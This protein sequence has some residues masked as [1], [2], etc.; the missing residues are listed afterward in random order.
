MAYYDGNESIAFCAGFSDVASQ[1]PCNATTDQFAFGSTTKV[2]TSVIIL[3]LQERGLLAL[4]DLLVDRA[5]DFFAKI[6]GGQLTLP[7]LM[8]GPELQQLTLRHLLQM[9]SGLPDYDD[10]DIRTY[11]NTHRD[12][13]RAVCFHGGGGGSFCNH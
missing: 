9:Q 8:P 6:A 5:G 4:D 10:Q 11:Q 1:A 7:Q 3:Q 13:V 12:E 2:T